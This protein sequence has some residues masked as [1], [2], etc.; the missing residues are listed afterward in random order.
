LH[1][2][3]YA[4]GGSCEQQSDT[5]PP[6]CLKIVLKDMCEK[7]QQVFLNN[8]KPWLISDKDGCKKRSGNNF[9]ID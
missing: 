7:H 8:Q 5:V 4:V 9:L 1:E 3:K 2:E 6:N